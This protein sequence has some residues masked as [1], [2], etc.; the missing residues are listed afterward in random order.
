M[1]LPNKLTI[2]RM[3]LVPFFVACFY[4]PF[5]A[6][7]LVAL[8]VFVLA[9]ITD[10]IDGRYARSHNIVTDF[11]KLMDPIADKLLSTAAFVM[12][13]AHGMMGPVPALMILAREFIISGIRSVSAGK[14][15][16]IAANNLGKIKTVTQCVAVGVILFAKF[17]EGL[18]MVGSVD[19]LWLIGQIILWVSVGFA[20]WS[21]LVYVLKNKTLLD[22]K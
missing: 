15:K 21:G 3:I 5:K 1:N 4:L 16:I 14:G 7:S 6:W 19:I 12:L 22:A 10:M 18:L 17:F 2:L 8:V 11:G 13:V 20:V 9:Y